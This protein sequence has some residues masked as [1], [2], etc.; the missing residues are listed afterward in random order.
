MP[1]VWIEVALEEYRML[2]Q[3]ILRA[4]QAR[5]SIAGHGLIVIGVLFAVAFATW[6][7]P[8]PAALLLLVVVPVLC[9]LLLVVWLGE[10][11]RMLDAGH[12]LGGL[13]ER[14]GA[15]FPGEPP[16][17][18][19][20][21]RLRD[22]AALARAARGRWGGVAVV[23]LFLF[24]AACAVVAGHL[25]LVGRLPVDLLLWIDAVEAVCLLAATGAVPLALRGLG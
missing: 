8:V 15:R 13:E 7:E 20:A 23:L 12:A 4:A 17:L 11:A 14:I 2:R 3:E 5:H 18:S 25:L 22:P 21:S 6:R 24:S 1:T 10:T 19:W 9:Y 16:P